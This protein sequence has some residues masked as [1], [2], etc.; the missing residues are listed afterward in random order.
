MRTYPK[1]LYYTPEELNENFKRF[2]YEALNVMLVGLFATSLLSFITSVRRF[3]IIPGG[4]PLVMI[5]GAIAIIV[6]LSIWATKGFAKESMFMLLIMSVMFAG[7]ANYVQMWNNFQAR[8]TITHKQ[9]QRL[10]TKAGNLNLFARLS[11]AKMIDK[12]PTTILANKAQYDK[13]MKSDQSKAFV[14]FKVG[15]PYCE[16]AHDTIVN[17]ARKAGVADKI[18]FVNYESDLGID[19]EYKYNIN[20]VTSIVVQSPGRTWESV[21]Q[22][23]Y[24]NG[25]RQL[26]PDTDSI[27]YAMQLL[28]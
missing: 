8:P 10:Y 5:L 1:S 21:S 27:K 3:G 9:A 22:S 2:C 17:E 6:L 13:L 18:H 15:C 4:S 12:Y 16:H 7:E 24:K 28:K 11:D 14:F 19:L 25:E 26:T 20:R 23:V